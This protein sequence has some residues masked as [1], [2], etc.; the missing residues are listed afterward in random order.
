MRCVFRKSIGEN[1]ACAVKTAAMTFE[2][3]QPHIEFMDEPGLRPAAARRESANI[4]MAIGH[5]GN[6]ELYARIIP[7]VPGYQFATTYRGL[8]QPSL[9]RLLRTLRERS[10]CLFFERR[11]EAKAL[12]ASMNAGG[13]L[14]GWL[15]D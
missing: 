7:I 5:F 1:Y 8:R 15:S 14:L 12:K 10:G 13:I 4:V 3:L 11:F 6:F 9:N 2:E